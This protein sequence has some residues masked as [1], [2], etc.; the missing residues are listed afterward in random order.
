MCLKYLKYQIFQETLTLPYFPRGQGASNSGWDEGFEIN[1][2][3]GP[4]IT[5][6]N[7]QNS[8]TGLQFP[9]GLWVS[10]DRRPGDMSLNSYTSP[11]TNE[12]PLPIAYFMTQAWMWNFPVNQMRCL[13]SIPPPSSSSS[14]PT[15]AELLN[16][17]QNDTKVTFKKN[18]PSS[19]WLC[20]LDL[21]ILNTHLSLGSTRN[22]L[23]GY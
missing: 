1:T 6:Q 4:K 13:F 8:Q 10:L 7:D 11:S 22:L 5:D 17:N 3:K 2:W 9:K 14:H 23:L 16:E 19:C 15:K 12:D 20:W 18:H 21:H